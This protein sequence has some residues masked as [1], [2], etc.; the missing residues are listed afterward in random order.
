MIHLT[1]QLA[2]WIAYGI[3]LDLRV[4]FINEKAYKL[5]VN[6]VSMFTGFHAKRRLEWMIGKHW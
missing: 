1:L 5:F 6:I 4:H 2:F 3:V